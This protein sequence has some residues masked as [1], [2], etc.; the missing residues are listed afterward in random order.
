MPIT[1]LHRVSHAMAARGHH[2]SMLH[3]RQR[4]LL[5]IAGLGQPLSAHLRPAHVLLVLLA[6]GHRRLH[7]LRAQVAVRAHG[8]LQVHLLAVFVM[9]VRGHQRGP[10]I[11][12]HA[13]RAHGLHL[14]LQPP[15]L[16][17][18]RAQ[19]VHIHR[20]LVHQAPA[21]ACFVAR[22]RGLRLARQA[23][24]HVCE[25]FRNFLCSF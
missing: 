13:M 4:A 19:L 16:H 17:A 2:L 10:H 7:P 3:P 25:T 22:V 15:L 9:L 5:A 20:P 21:R 23:V 14:K 24:H 1:T 11:V 6:C 18:L 8:L 12:T